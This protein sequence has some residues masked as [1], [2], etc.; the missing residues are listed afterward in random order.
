DP[1]LAR[2]VAD[3]LA[4]RPEDRAATATGLAVRLRGLDCWGAWDPLAVEA[5][6]AGM[7]V[8]APPPGGGSAPPGPRS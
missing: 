5:W 8:S 1:G 3:L 7:P 4:K 6:W 2:I